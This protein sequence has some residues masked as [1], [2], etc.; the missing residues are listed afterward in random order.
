MKL[1]LREII[2]ALLKGAP[3]HEG[4]GGRKS[5]TTVLSP[6]STSSQEGVFD[7]NDGKDYLMIFKCKFLSFLLNFNGTVTHK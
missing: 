4:G 1:K 6:F 7:A 3:D 2:A 5:K